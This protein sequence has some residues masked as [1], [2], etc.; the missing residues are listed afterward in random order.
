MTSIALPFSVDKWRQRLVLARVETRFQIA[1][2]YCI[3]IQY[4]LF[5]V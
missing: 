2:L 5:P 3:F 4:Q 1:L